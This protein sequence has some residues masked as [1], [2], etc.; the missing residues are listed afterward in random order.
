[1]INLKWGWRVSCQ[2]LGSGGEFNF[3]KVGKRRDGSRLHSHDWAWFFLH[4]VVNEDEK[5][6]R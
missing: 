5:H 4:N 2:R 3:G 6:A 1:M